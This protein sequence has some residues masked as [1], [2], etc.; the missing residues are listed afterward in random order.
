MRVPRAN[1]SIKDGQNSLRGLI[2]N[3]NG[4]RHFFVNPA[5]CR[6]IDK[7]LKTVQL[8]KGSTFQEEDSEYQHVTTTLRYYTAVKHPIKRDFTVTE[9]VGG[10]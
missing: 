3:A 5:K 7:G 1:P 4:E 2:M 8:K 10:F 6:Y 9:S